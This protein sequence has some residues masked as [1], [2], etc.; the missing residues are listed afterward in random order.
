MC[1]LR[2]LH[3]KLFARFWRASASN[4]SLMGFL[5]KE[6]V[7]AGFPVWVVCTIWSYVA[8]FFSVRYSRLRMPSHNSINVHV[9]SIPKFGK[10]TMADIFSTERHHLCE[11]GK[12]ESP[13]FSWGKSHDKPTR[14]QSWW[15]PPTLFLGFLLNSKPRPELFT[16]VKKKRE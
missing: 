12:I 2:Q 6:T 9:P 14:Q 10:N 3:T 13:R 5:L 11:E 7:S 15:T 16:I 1:L 8:L 4:C